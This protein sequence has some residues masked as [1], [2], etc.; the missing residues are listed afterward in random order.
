M[1]LAGI[2]CNSN[3]VESQN[4]QEEELLLIPVA[5]SDFENI[6]KIAES[7]MI[8][9]NQQN[10]SYIKCQRKALLAA[11]NTDTEFGP[12][13]TTKGQVDKHCIKEP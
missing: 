11:S 12:I 9:R 7:L 2:K 8:A 13:F 6:N 5:K 3:K 4:L 1:T 10:S